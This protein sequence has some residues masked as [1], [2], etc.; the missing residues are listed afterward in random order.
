M[1]YLALGEYEKSYEYSSQALKNSKEMPGSNLSFIFNN[2]GVSFQKKASL[3]GDLH[4]YL[5]AMGCFR[6]KLDLAQEGGDESST[7]LA[8][9]NIGDVYVDLKQYE[10]A[11]SFLQPSYEMARRRNDPLLIGTLLHSIGMVHLGRE[12]FYEAEKVFDRALKD[13]QKAG[14]NTLMMKSHYGLAQ[15]L[16]KRGEYGRA[17]FHYHQSLGIID[18]IGSRIRDDVSRAGFIRNKMDIYERLTDLY[19]ELFDKGKSTIFAYEVFNTAEKAKA[20][21]FVELLEKL[22]RSASADVP[23]ETEEEEKLKNSRLDNLRKLATESLDVEKKKD[24]EFMIRRVEDRLMAGVFERLSEETQDLRPEPVTV[25][26]LQKYVLDGETA[27]IEYILGEGRSFM[28]LISKDSYHVVPLLPHSRI[29][30]SLIA[31]LE[32]LKDPKIDERKGIAAAERLYGE[33]F[34]PVERWIPASVTKL[35]IIPDGILY[36]LPFETLIPESGNSIKKDFLV[37]R[38]AISY[39]PSA[40]ALAYL[41]RAH[42][43]REFSKD[44]L[45]FGAPYYPK[46]AV[47]NEKNPQAPARIMFELY[48]QNGYS[49]SPIGYSKKEVSAISRH[50]RPGRKDVYLGKKADEGIFKA[51]NLHDYRIIHFACH[52]FSEENFPLRS[53][54]VLSLSA[55]DA[56]DGFL[57]VFEMY[58]MRLRSDLVV[59]SACQTGRGKNIRGEGIL[60][61]PRIFFYMG[62]RSVVSTLWAIDDKVTARFMEYFYSY[63]SESGDKTQSLRQA[64][65]KMM[66]SI[67]SHP[68]YWGAFVLTGEP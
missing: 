22:G 54:L 59:L 47:F 63:F 66:E 62:S 10:K 29:Q 14:N 55:R 56:E 33:L 60:G 17:F 26:A 30:D 35:I 44:F 15:C 49:F 48:K 65:L 7:I 43:N 18:A 25:G 34:R 45:A 8:M 20:R 37:K 40:S 31:Y 52:A 46:S 6:S 42:E 57:Q 38:W 11:L 50:F 41:A 2:L 9:N 53:A 5:R 24:M 12:N 28:I 32:F 16:E 1:T 67:Y 4:D 58:N 27:L 21:A 51:L 3:T 68:F 23:K 64:K 19:Y 61:L 13:A 36:S 39:A